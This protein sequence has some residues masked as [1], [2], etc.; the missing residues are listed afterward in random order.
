MPKDSNDCEVMNELFD[1]D[2]H[3]HPVA[4]YDQ[5]DN[6]IRDLT[7]QEMLEWLKKERER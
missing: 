2:V 3:R 6:K 5:N 4:E 1:S 7:P